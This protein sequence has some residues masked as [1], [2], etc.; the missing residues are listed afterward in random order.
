MK[1][2]IFF[3]VFANI[4]LFAQNSKIY[5]KNKV[6]LGEENTFVYEPQRGTSI[7]DNAFV[8]YLYKGGERKSPLK[9]ISNKFE[10]SAIAPDSIR[11]MVMMVKNPS[12]S[13]K[14]TNSN[15][16]FTYNLIDKK[17]G[18]TQIDR[19]LLMDF[20]NYLFKIDYP[21]SKVATEYENV[22]KAFPQT[23]TDENY[24]IYL[25]ALNIANPDLAKPVMRQYAE[26]MQKRTDEKSLISAYNIYNFSLKELEKAEALSKLI[27]E[28]YPNGNLAKRDFV[29]NF[30]GNLRNAPETLNED[31]N[32]LKAISDFKEKFLK[33][34]MIIRWLT[35]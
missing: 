15:N 25:N 5:P 18:K 9:K 31:C 34:N 13:F 24:S 22:F 28:K 6:I 3:L 4:L 21:W 30:F 33:K 14:D 16:L 20:V 26:K 10:F 19:L 8:H 17:D 1:K 23:K 35:K 2:Y 32:I 12:E 11:T 27:L 7:P 29:R